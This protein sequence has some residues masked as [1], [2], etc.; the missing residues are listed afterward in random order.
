MGC[1]CRTFRE[2][3]QARPCVS[4]AE[5]SSNDVRRVANEGSRGPA[6]ATSLWNA[7]LGRGFRL[8][9]EPA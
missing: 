3:H 1:S 6:R 2:E 8:A 9:N 4:E 7:T 5:P